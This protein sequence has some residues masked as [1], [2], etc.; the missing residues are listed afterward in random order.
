MNCVLQQAGEVVTLA[1][2]PLLGARGATSPETEP[3]PHGEISKS[4]ICPDEATSPHPR[5]QLFTANY[6]KRKGCK[7]AAVVPRA[8][9]PVDQRLPAE[10]LTRLPFRVDPLDTDPV[11]G[12]IFMDA[13]A[14]GACQCCTQV[15]L[16]TR[17]LEEARFLTDQFLVLAPLFLALTAATPFYRGLV[18]D[19]DT[20]MPAFY[21]TWDDRR[22]D[23]LETVRNSRCSAN[24]LFIGR[25]L[26]DDAQREADVNDVQVP[27]CGAALRCL[28]EAGV[29]PVLSRHA[30]HVLARDPLCVFKD[31]L[32]IDDETNNDHWEQLQG[33][34]WGNV[35]FKP[36]PGVHSDI[37]W[38]V[39]FRSPEVAWTHALRQIGRHEE[40]ARHVVASNA[41]TLTLAMRWKELRDAGLRCDV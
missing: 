10:E 17:N 35:R 37:G 31:R 20:R 40:T 38:R 19:F 25:S 11:P 29:D 2:F 21:Q 13:L 16:L 39:E 18:S 34:N 12:H 1:N 4:T 8:G 36:P 15:T 27:V 24:D 23:E 3:A 32:E 41:R 6:R 33:T 9:L 5:Y 7:V 30:A 22:E 14:F 28:M 26:V